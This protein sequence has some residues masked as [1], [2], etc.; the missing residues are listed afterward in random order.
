MDGV[1]VKDFGAPLGKAS[2]ATRDFLLGDLVVSDTPLLA[3]P[4]DRVASS[5][6]D[7]LAEAL[8]TTL[9]MSESPDAMEAATAVDLQVN[10]I[11]QFEKDMTVDQ[12]EAVLHDFARP[13]ED[14]G[15]A[16]VGIMKDFADAAAK[17]D[18]ITASSADILTLLLV[19]AT[20]AHE[21]VEDQRVWVGLYGGGS[22]LAHSCSP[23][24][25]YVGAGPTLAHYALRDIRAGEMIT[26]NYTVRDDIRACWPT[27]LR[28]AKLEQ[29]KFFTC[30]CTRCEANDDL[31]TMACPACKEPSV[32]PP[33]FTCLTCGVKATETDLPLSVETTLEGSIAVATSVFDDPEATPDGIQT[34]FKRMQIVSNMAS[35]SLGPDHWISNWTQPFLT[36]RAASTGDS[37]LAARLAIRWCRW[38]SIHIR[39][40]LPHIHARHLVSM[41]PH[42][43]R[44]PDRDEYRELARSALPWAT[45]HFMGG[46]E[47][48]RRLRMLVG[49]GDKGGKSTSSTSGARERNVRQPPAPALTDEQK[50]GFLPPSVTQQQKAK[51]KGRK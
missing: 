44:G 21:F 42:C 26:T 47:P 32:R 17:V 4:T 14:A 29:T 10:A 37:V 27:S 13:P 18:G 36:L 28:R 41:G 48:V 22:K 15:Y 12:R 49:D 6:H 5:L 35:T 3:I 30:R 51:G 25:V 9:L 16:I 8:F 39:P 34:A 40:H 43:V 20:N 11:I 50:A 19:L 7:A 24:T 45:A 31:R 46:E 2:V 1:Q 23:M 33:T 38:S